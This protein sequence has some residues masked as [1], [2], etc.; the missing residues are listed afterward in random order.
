MT[1]EAFAEQHRLRLRRNDCGEHFIPCRRG[2]ILDYGDGRFGV[3]ILND[4][5]RVWGNARR[6]MEAAHFEILQ[7]GEEEGVGLFDPTNAR[8]VKV[9]FKVAKPCRRKNLSEETLA[10]LSRQ[11]RIARSVQKNL[12]SGAS[13]GQGSIASLG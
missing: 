11:V 6:S 10:K 2:Q 3:M 4:S 5:P 1:V 9:A 7:D 13:G 8:Q 12:N